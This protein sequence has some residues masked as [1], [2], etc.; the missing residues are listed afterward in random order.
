MLQTKA[1]HCNIF[2]LSNIVKAMQ[3]NSV[4]RS[5]APRLQDKN[6]LVRKKEQILKL[7]LT[8]IQCHFLS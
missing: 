6:M 4:K 7:L 2:N 3:K 5:V 8:Q 1:I